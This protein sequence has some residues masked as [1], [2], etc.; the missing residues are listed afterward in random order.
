MSDLKVYIAN[1][2]KYNEGELVGAWFT[3]PVSF[4]DVKEKIGL[5]DEYEEFAIHDYELP[6]KISEYI[7]LEELN[8]I[9]DMLSELDGTPIYNN[10]SEIINY[11]FQDLNDLFEHRDEINCYSDCFSMEDVAHYYIDEC[12]S[13]GEIPPDLHYYIDYAGYGRDIETAGN[14]LITSNGVFEF[15][16]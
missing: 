13:F 2:G 12:Q 1:L 9:A 3:L 14:F 7:S 10:L 16:S 15:I 8:D 11:W 4:E 5:N 6:V